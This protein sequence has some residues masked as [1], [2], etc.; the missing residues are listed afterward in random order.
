MSAIYNQGK[1]GKAK[2]YGAILGMSGDAIKGLQWLA[3]NSRADVAE[4]AKAF[5]IIYQA[6][7]S[8]KALADVSGV[9]VLSHNQKLIAYEY[10]VMDGLLEKA[11]SEKSSDGVLQ[12]DGESG[13]EGATTETSHKRKGRTT[14]EREAARKRQIE[15]ERRRFNQNSPERQKYLKDKYNQY[16]DVIE[17]LEVG[18]KLINDNGDVVGEV[19]SIFEGCIFVGGEG[20]VVEFILPDTFTDDCVISM[21]EVGDGHFEKPDGTWI[22]KTTA[23]SAETASKKITPDMSD[24]ERYEVLKDKEIVV[25]SSQDG[26]SGSGEDYS[27]Y[28]EELEKTNSK[29]KSKVEGLI[30][31]LADKLGILNVSKSSPAIEID[32][33]FSKNNGLK[34]SLSRQLDYGGGYA[35]FAKALINFDVVLENAI[36]I[37]EHTD[38]YKGKE[39]EDPHLEKVY[40]LFSAFKDGRFIIP[41]QLEIKKSSDVGGVLYV[42]VAMTKIEADV[43]ESTSDEN[44]VTHSLVSAPTYS[45]AEI[46]KNVNTADKHFLKYLPDGFLSEEQIKAKQEALAEDKRRIDA[47]PDRQQYAK[48]NAIEP[49]RVVYSSEKAM[50]YDAVVEEMPTEAEKSTETKV[51]EG[52]IVM[53]GGE[54]IVP[55]KENTAEQTRVIDMGKKLGVSVAFGK[56]TKDGKNIDGFFDGKVIYI[57]PNTTSGQAA[58]ILFKHEFTHFLE[59]RSSKYGDFVAAVTSSKAFAKFVKSKGFK[60][61]VE[62]YNK[63]IADY[64]QIKKSLDL[65]GAQAEAVANFCAERLYAKDDSMQ[66]FVDALSPDHKRTFGELIRDFIAWIKKK[67]GTLSEIEML[68]RQYAKLFKDAKKVEARSTVKDEGGEYAFEAS[69]EQ[70]AEWE[71]PITMQDVETLRSIGR[72]SINDFTSEEIKIAQK[73]AYKFYKELGIKSPFFRAWFGDWRQYERSISVNILKME[74]REGKNPRGQYKNNDTG[75]IINSSSVGYDETISHSG[76]DKKSIIAMQNID[77]IIE[78]AVL[79]DTEISEYGRGKKSIYTAFMHKFYAPISIDGTTYIAKMAVDESHAPGQNDT[80]KKFYHVRAIEIETASSVGIGKNHTPIMEDTVSNISISDLYGFVKA[81]DKDFSPAPEVSKQVLSEDG[82]PKVFYH[83]TDFDFDA[84]SYDTLG[85]STGVGILGEGFYFADTKNLAKKYGKNVKACYLKM[86]NPYI[87]SES[88]LY[89]LRTD[90]LSA[91]GYDGVI[92][93]SPKGDIYMIFDNTQIKSATDNIGTFDGDNPD[94]NYSY[95]PAEENSIDTYTEEQYNDGTAYSYT[96]KKKKHRYINISQE[97]LRDIMWEL[98]DVYG[99]VKTAVADEVAVAL[100]N[101]VYVVDSGRENGKITC[102]AI[103]KIIIND[104]DFR[105]EYIRRT[106]YDALSKGCVSDGLSARFR[107]K[108]AGRGESDRRSSIRQDLQTNNGESANNQKRIPQGSGGNADTGGLIESD[109]SYTP[110]KAETFDELLKQYKEGTITEEEFK[111]RIV[112]GKSKNDPV[113]VARMSEEV[114]FD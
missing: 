84:F 39:R 75:W 102:R 11:R 58:F 89:R 100:G 80:N 10:G 44:T 37:E 36:L 98:R 5:N 18:D 17:Q 67:L 94:I 90:K 61:S 99:D 109:Y 38:K 110:S 14:E 73:W 82:T 4:L 28:I 106:N 31:D 33:T 12:N 46:F 111:E 48:E 24:A 88:E 29:A 68:E 108:Y 74:H 95:T 15:S 105:E 71:K 92:L 26:N 55:V 81:F 77:K 104:K 66:R 79:L 7:K 25:Q 20:G 86:S 65:A 8:G 16:R 41:V 49:E 13:K 63:I 112:G 43:L 93:K 69:K 60:N 34:K 27:S 19:V 35:D 57:N 9:D 76:K 3:S 114:T 70:I 32:F 85:N 1:S 103:E 83:G 51:P 78:N 2:L 62:Y 72:K 56:I 50:A 6:A 40:V 87:A 107:R 101:T 54:V 64:K 91:Q 59:R 96:P 30:R 22:G 21:L 23:D 45:I 97:T 113:S 42:N 53:S 52:A 47:M